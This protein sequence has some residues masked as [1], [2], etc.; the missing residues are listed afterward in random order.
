MVEAWK[1]MVELVRNPGNSTSAT[2]TNTLLLK[3]MELFMQ[4]LSSRA[5]QPAV[6]GGPG[7]LEML[8]RAVDL[9]DKLRGPSKEDGVGIVTSGDVSLVTEGGKVNK[10][11]SALL[12]VTKTINGTV[13]KVGS[14]LQAARSDGAGPRS[15]KAAL[16]AATSAPV[17]PSAI[18]AALKPSTS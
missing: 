1:A 16:T 2:E 5:A 17:A 3:M 15:P 14:M 7:A 9:I 18:A 13:S 10:D 11:L 8:D 4:N 12:S 6:N